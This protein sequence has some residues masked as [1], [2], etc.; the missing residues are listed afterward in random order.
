MKKLNK[1]NQHSSIKFLIICLVL[2]LILFN[3]FVYAKDEYFENPEYSGYQFTDISLPSSSIME[4]GQ[5]VQTF[6]SEFDSINGFEIMFGLWAR[7]NTCN[8]HVTLSK[9]DGDILYEWNVNCADFKDN[10]FQKFLMDAPISGLR[11]QKLQVILESDA[12]DTSN[13]I[14]PYIGKIQAE[15]VRLTINGDDPEGKSLYFQP[16]Y[17]RAYGKLL[18]YGLIGISAL[19]LL[20]ISFVLVKKRNVPIHRLWLG[21]GGSLFILYS[22]VIPILRV[23]DEARHFLRA[24][25]ISNGH[26][27]ASYNDDFSDVGGKFPVGLLEDCS[28]ANHSDAFDILK[29]ANNSAE[30]MEF[31]SYINTAVYSPIS[32]LPQSVGVLLAR[33]FSERT[34]VMFYTAR[35]LS[36]GVCFFLI[37]IALKIAP[38]GKSVIFL[39][40]CNPM[41]LQEAISLAPDGVTNSLSLLYLSFVLYLRKKGQ[42]LYK[43]EIFII[44]GLTIWMCSMKLVY[45]PICL[46]LF[47]IPTECFKSKN[48]KEMH[49]IICALTILVCSLGWLIAVHGF[50]ELF[51]DMRNAAGSKGVLD[52]LCHPYHT[53]MFLFKTLKVVGTVLILDMLGARLGGF[54]IQIGN[55]SALIWL[56]LLG[57]C[58]VFTSIKIQKRESLGYR[59]VCGSIPLACFLLI[60]FSE[61]AVWSPIGSEILDGFMGRYF[62]PMIYPLFLCVTGVSVDAVKYKDQQVEWFMNYDNGLILVVSALSLYAVGQITFQ[63]F[64]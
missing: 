6:L 27:V 52:L 1:L 33:L 43:T 15:D 36:A 40:T 35:I 54:D 44:Y 5:Y 58:F 4:G 19:L 9:E 34:M 3:S 62:I 41:F 2:L 13:A 63:C 30:K 16:I 11:G 61:Y 38:V 60:F 31:R 18:L 37:Y 21:I 24:Y 48:S 53:T 17:N 12:T 39:V 22:T 49:T 28:W 46:S 7:V 47:L 56:V 23:P 42:L 25:E 57:G 10:S 45:A 64:L 32:Y 26:L 29:D 14:I 59:V 20:I 50:S 51:A 55:F 8:L